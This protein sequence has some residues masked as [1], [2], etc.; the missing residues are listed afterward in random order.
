MTDLL[1]GFC[2]ALLIYAA[3]AKIGSFHVFTGSLEWI[4]P[5]S[6][7]AR[8][9]AKGVIAVEMILGT[10]LFVLWFRPEATTAAM[11]L[12]TVFTVT[13]AY[14]RLRRLPASC[15]CFGA[16]TEPITVSVIARDAGLVLLLWAASFSG[17]EGSINFTWTG[18]AAFLGLLT[19]ST[20]RTSLGWIREQP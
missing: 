2:G 14:A 6:R 4:A 3:I 5:S 16:H 12:M 7:S 15:M 11:M 9:L 17:R 18:V 8:H 19:F 13:L 20:L 10:S 1:A